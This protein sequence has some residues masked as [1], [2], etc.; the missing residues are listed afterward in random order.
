MKHTLFL[1]SL[2]LVALL[3]PGCSDQPAPVDSATPVLAWEVGGDAVSFPNDYLTGWLDME[4]RFENTDPAYE[5]HSGPN[6][7]VDEAH[8]NFHTAGGI[9]L[10]FAELLR[11]DGYPVT[12]FRSRFTEDALS[13]CQILLIVNAQAR[14]NIIA[15]D[16]PESNR[17]YPHASAFSRQEID[18][19]ILWVRRGGN[20]LLI[21]D[22]AP[23]PAAVSDLALLLGV[24]MFDGYALVSAEEKNGT[25]AFGT[26]NEEVWQEAN[27]VVGELVNLDYNARSMP[28]LTNPGALAPHP[29]VEGRNPRERIEW[30]VTYGGQAF[31]ASDDWLPITVFGP[32]AVSVAPLSFNFDG[33]EWHDGPLFSAAGWLN[34]ATRRLEQGRVAILGEGGMCTAQFDDLDGEIDDPLEPYG[35]NAPQAP[36]NAQYCLNVM[37]WLSG[38]LE[39]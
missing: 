15:F 38:L 24:H 16:L 12:P 9:F 1:T 4:Y 7:C 21:A 39:E 34:G 36:Y 27:R 22:H 5:E 11:G 29:V 10:P 13:N 28:T 8:F 35:F 32:G 17:A 2:L 23:L 30:I 14:A 31:L 25:V 3:A 26:V 18:Q 33:A 37:H 20:L 19:L 6:V